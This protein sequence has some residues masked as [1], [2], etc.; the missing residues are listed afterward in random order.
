MREET[1]IPYSRTG[2]ERKLV[3]FSTPTGNQALREVADDDDDDDDEAERD[4]GEDDDKSTEIMT[5]MATT[6]L[7]VTMVR[8]KR[9]R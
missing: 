9:W 7:I 5:A 4:A 6:I 2:G 8:H 1:T 3:I